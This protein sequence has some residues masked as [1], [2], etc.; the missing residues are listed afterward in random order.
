MI[1]ARQ[2]RVLRAAAAATLATF[3][4]L[5]CHVAA[6]GALPALAGV[7]LPWALSLAVCSVLAGRELSL[8]RLSLAVGAAQALFHTLFVVGVMPPAS[9]RT[10]SPVGGHHHGHMPFM[11]SDLST[12]EPANAVLAHLE[13]GMLLAHGLA[14][15]CTIAALHRG[16]RL[17]RSLVALAGRIGLRLR[18][19]VGATAV[20]L[21]SFRMP[22]AAASGFIVRPRPLVASPARRGPPVLPAF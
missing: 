6:G 10:S 11:E 12:G 19:L 8:V 9:N 4:A 13:P 16:E 18:R 14:A 15:V 2:Q 21:P 17:L 20:P 1:S 3:V 7:A 22:E 5:L